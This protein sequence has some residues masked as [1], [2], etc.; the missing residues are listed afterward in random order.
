[1]GAGRSLVIGGSGQIGAQV[2]ELLGA[3]KC[4][5]ASRRMTRESGLGLDLGAIATDD[6][7]ES[8]LRGHAVNAIYCIAGMTDVEACEG[9]PR[10]A[11][12]VNCRG[13]AMLARTAARRGIPFVYFST[14]YVF[15][16]ATAAYGR[17]GGPYGESD[18]MNPLSVYGQ[19]KARGEF[20]VRAACPHALILRTTVVYGED[21]GEKNFLYS[22]MRSLRAGRPMRVAQDQISTPTYNRDLASATVALAGSS[23]SGVYHV[24]GP[25]RMDRLQFA[26]AAARLLDLDAGLLVGVPTRAL[27]Q[28]AQRPLSAGLSIEK[29]RRQHREIRMRTMAE[30]LADCRPALEAFLTSCREDEAVCWHR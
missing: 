20:A 10:L 26:R 12:A 15:D 3:A 7:A 17:L 2:L 4:L 16:G 1:M 21:A 18:P 14:E 24:C 25:E 29:L 23:A 27:G 11:Y 8:L 19:S 30:A 22:L 6:D 9:M 28:K 13:P 5:I